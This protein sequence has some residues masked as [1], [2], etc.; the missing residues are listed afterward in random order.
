M[1]GIKK[2][3]K[4]NQCMFV[5]TPPHFQ[6]TSTVTLKSSKKVAFGGSR[7]FLIKIVV[8][9]HNNMEIKMDTQQNEAASMFVTTP[10][11]YNGALCCN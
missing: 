3:T 10:Y 6:G 2:D 1:T 9:T 8:L 5:T 7:L 11:G 4:E